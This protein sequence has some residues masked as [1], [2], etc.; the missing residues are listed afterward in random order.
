MLSCLPRFEP[1][2]QMPSQ[3]RLIEAG[4]GLA[5]VNQAS[6]FLSYM[7]STIDPK[8]NPQELGIG[9]ST[10]HAVQGLCDLDLEPFAG[11]AF[12]VDTMASFL[13]QYPF[14]SFLFG[15]FEKCFA[16][17]KMI[18]VAKSAANIGDL[19]QSTFSLLKRGLSADR[20][21]P[22]KEDRKRNTRRRCPVGMRC[23]GHAP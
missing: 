21:R 7:P 1:S 20:S 2:F 11:A 16:L 17:R 5:H 6:P 14:Q 18:G 22:H 12:F 23:A 8:C 10:D 13:G 4:T 9:V 19:R 3:Q 15:N